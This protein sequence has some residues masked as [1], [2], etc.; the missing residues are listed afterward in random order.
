MLPPKRI[1][2]V[3]DGFEFSVGTGGDLSWDDLGAIRDTSR[4]QGRQ[5][6]AASLR[7]VVEVLRVFPGAEVLP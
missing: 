6:P 3:R 1:V 2:I 5:I 7:A 4:R